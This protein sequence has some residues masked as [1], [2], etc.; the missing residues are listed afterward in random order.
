MKTIAAATLVLV[1]CV[2]RVSGAWGFEAHQFI[3]D[4]AIGLLPPEIRP[5]FEAHRA[6]LVERVID[7]DT[8]RTAGFDDEDP[9]HFLDID[10]EGFGPY[11]FAAL[12]RDYSAAVQK[13][14]ADRIRQEGLLPWRTEE[15][16]GNLRRAFERYP[17]TGPFG[18]YNVIFFAAWMS[19]YV[20]DANQP[21]HGVVNYNGQLTGQTGVHVRFESTLFER[22]RSRLQVAPKP[23]PAITDPRGFIFD[24]VTE[25]TRQV[26][27]ILKADTDAIGTRDVYDQAYYDAF[28][29]G[30]RPVMEER[31]ARS[32]ASVAAM[33]TGAWEAAGRPAV[34]LAPAEPVQRR[35]R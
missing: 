15:F 1:L 7:P 9:H 4:Q 3:M 20:S 34:P 11:P 14:G 10:F 22:Y 30:A 35:R 28:F 21:L 19:H 16:Y 8:W 17:S 23:M 24:T 18:R 26:P 27:A 33:I 5:F 12:A 2:P 32:I 13:F 31:L 6:T 25:G 29:T